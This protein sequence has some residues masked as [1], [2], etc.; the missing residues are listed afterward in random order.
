MKEVKNVCHL[1]LV[2][3]FSYFVQGFTLIELLVVVLV[4]GVLAAVALP[5]YQKAVLKSRYTTVM[6]VAKKLADSNE[7][8]YMEH[9]EYA[10]HPGEL[11]V[12]A[13]D[14]ENTTVSLNPSQQKEDYNYV[15]ASRTDF[16]SAR[17]IVYQKHS[18][19]FPGHVHCEASDEQAE[20]LCEK[21]LGGT[22][23]EGSVNNNNAKTYILEGTSGEDVYFPQQCSGEGEKECSCGGPIEGTCNDKTGD[24]IFEGNCPEPD[25]NAE[26]TESCTID[27]KSGTRSR[28]AECKDG[29]YVNEWSECVPQYVVGSNFAQQVKQ[30]QEQYR[31][32]HGSYATTLEQLGL[33]CPEGVRCAINSGA[34]GTR[35]ELTAIVFYDENGEQ[36]VAFGY[37]Y[38]TQPSGSSYPSVLRGKV[39]C[40][41]TSA[42]NSP[43]ITRQKEICSQY[44][45]LITGYD[46]NSWGYFYDLK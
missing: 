19:N 11:D 35:N 6:P 29:A 20:W 44:G 12:T 34:G 24:W 40:R 16:P 15:V 43:N 41:P 2:S 9:G 18:S 46:V 23:I 38:A 8:Y 14:A 17:Y 42:S 3:G 32:T 10:L 45:T 36:L 4:I 22:F 21:G 30:L 7:I 28:H 13:A 37:L 39:Y 1:E 33:T 31:A 26:V 27:G 25:P 5:Q